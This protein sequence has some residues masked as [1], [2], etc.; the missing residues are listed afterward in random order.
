[1]LSDDTIFEVVREDDV[2]ALNELHL[3]A[4]NFEIETNGGQRLLSYALIHHSLNAAAELI[5]FGMDIDDVGSDGYTPLTTICFEEETYSAEIRLLAEEDVDLNLADDHGFTPLRCA[6]LKENIPNINT[7]IEQ[8]AD[9]NGTD[10]ILCSPLVFAI[11]NNNVQ[12]VEILLAAGA[13]PNG[14]SSFHND[15]P[16]MAALRRYSLDSTS[17]FVD[18]LLAAGADVS[19]PGMGPTPTPFLLALALQQDEWAQE[20]IQRGC[21]VYYRQTFAMA[22][23]DA[24]A[25]TLNVSFTNPR[26]TL[27]NKLL[28]GSGE[29]MLPAQGQILNLHPIA[30]NAIRGQ[31]EFTLQ[32]IVRRF[33]RKHLLRFRVNLIKQVE[34][35]PLTN[36][37]KAYLLYQ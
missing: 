30:Q 4:T 27:R 15:T 1:M 23:P 33:L 14:G 10:D 17:V 19:T 2:D 32:A 6:I 34:Q 26:A 12:A 3:Q 37:T 8:G 36:T 7:L 9:P 22:M 24:I 11:E 31:N 13:T 16:L 20:F 25:Q 29:V 35:L 18:R 21:H 28:F 5:A